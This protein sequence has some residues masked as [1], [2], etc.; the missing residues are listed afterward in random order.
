MGKANLRKNNT[1]TD[2][3]GKPER[4]KP[5]GQREGF[6]YNNGDYN[7]VSLVC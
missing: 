5:R 1:N 6:H 3:R 4:E 2:L 7:G